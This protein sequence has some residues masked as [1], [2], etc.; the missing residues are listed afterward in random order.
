MLVEAV[1]DAEEEVPDLAVQIDLVD[2]TGR[3]TRPKPPVAELQL[4]LGY[5]LFDAA[6][7]P[8]PPTQMPM[9]A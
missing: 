4:D 9:N 3:T 6:E 2:S 1:L 8:C 5:D 7:S